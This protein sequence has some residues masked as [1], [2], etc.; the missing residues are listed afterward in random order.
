MS[1]KSYRTAKNINQADLGKRLG[2]DQPRMSRLEANESA[3]SMAIALRVL[4]VTGE[5]IGPL[6]NKTPSAI[7]LLRKLQALGV[8]L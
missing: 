6:A 2:L 7:R 8:S 1:L 5:R 3:A 4:E